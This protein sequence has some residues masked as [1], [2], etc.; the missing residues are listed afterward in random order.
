LIASAGN[1]QE[2]IP[3]AATRGE[4][5]SRRFVA[6]MFQQSYKKPAIAP[7]KIQIEI[8]WAIVME[9]LAKI[10]IGL[11]GLLQRDYFFD[12]RV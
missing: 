4:D 5:G 2:K 12:K 11:F 9:V 10:A 3:K 1:A 7:E 8:G 6:V